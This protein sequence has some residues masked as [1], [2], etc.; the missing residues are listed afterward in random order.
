M[1]EIMKIVLFSILVL[2]GVQI[3]AQL[4]SDRNIRAEIK[5]ITKERIERVEEYLKSNDAPR[6]KTKGHV[7]QVIHDIVD[8]KP[9]YRSTDNAG[10]ADNTFT[11]SLWP[12]GS[13]GLDLEGENLVVGV[14]E[15]GGITR[16]S[17]VEYADEL[18][19]RVIVKDGS[20]NQTFH[21]T[22]V[23]GTI[24]ASGL[25]T[26]SR[27]MAPK[28][29]VWNYNTNNVT[30]EIADA[31]DEIN[32]LISNHSYGVSIVQDNGTL[33]VSYMGAYNNDART[34]DLIANN[35]PFH[36]AVFSAG[37]NGNDQYEGG[38][39]PN[40]DKLTGEKNSKN[41][42]VVANVSSVTYFGDL[43]I[44]SINNSS[45]RGPSDDGRIKPD[46]GGMGT[47]IL[48][49][50]NQADDAYGTA[51]GTSMAGPGVAGSLILLQELFNNE[52][53]QFL[54]SATLKAVALNTAS[55]AGNAGPDA[56]YGW[57]ILNS[58][59]AANAILDKE[60]G[61]SV[62]SEQN[63]SE[64]ETIT[65]QVTANGDEAIK[66]MIV[67]ND[68][69][70]TAIN[71]TE[72]SPTPALV[73]DLDLRVT[74]N[75]ET[76]LPWKLQL[77]DVTAPAIK[78]DNIVDNVEQVIVDN[79]TAG[80]VYTVEISHK[81]SLTNN[82]QD[83]SVVVTGID[84]TTLNNEDFVSEFDLN[85]WPNPA[86]NYIN[87]SFGDNL[88][89]NDGIIRIYDLM[90][91]LVHQEKVNKKQDNNLRVDV[92]NLNKGTYIMNITTGNSNYNSKFIK[93]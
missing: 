82:Q 9:I 26:E 78:E 86:E 83:V 61:S 76:F 24:A 71:N 36:L 57:G 48:S 45:S 91:K 40:F 4:T 54:K 70:G 1:K 68:P 50:G 58:E 89:A 13:L 72:N 10:A 16:T 75:Q 19:S 35:N 64:G 12:G 47:D 28:S 67:W 88:L 7:I 37:N 22:H 41:N 87:I 21:S 84:S 59:K 85:Y 6:T 81:G 53:G 52:Y 30:S 62:V 38:L 34:W 2:M 90:G 63:L 32:L 29:I 20:G 65:F 69:A 14:W 3:N 11:S 46:I 80:T 74:L 31:I 23:T 25:N 17:H 55:D 56:T 44:S 77:S 92:S 33:P 15:V 66:A 51:T 5:S 49:T 27:G 42:M 79:P 93:K 73:N 43:I 8:G 39:A 60:A 18:G